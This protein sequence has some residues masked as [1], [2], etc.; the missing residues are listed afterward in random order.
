MQQDTDTLPT[1][2][3]HASDWLQPHQ[4]S[5]HSGGINLTVTEKKLVVAPVAENKEKTAGWW[6]GSM[7]PSDQL[8]STHT[9]YNVDQI[10]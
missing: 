3:W 7:K 8:S 6:Q 2:I 5:Y 1:K 9:S 10:V 4:L